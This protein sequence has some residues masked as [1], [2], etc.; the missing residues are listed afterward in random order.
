LREAKIANARKTVEKAQ[1][2][3]D[4]ASE[5]ERADRERTLESAKQDLQRI[6]NDQSEDQDQIAA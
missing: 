1:A 3:V 6:E 5:E 2:D 4:I